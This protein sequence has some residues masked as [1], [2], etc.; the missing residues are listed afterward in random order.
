MA[1]L[2]TDME[3][4]QAESQRNATRTPSPQLTPCEQ[5]KY[6]K[7]QLAKME[8]FRRCKQACVDA[9]MMMPDHHP[10]E[11]FYVRALTELHDIEE[12]MALAVSTHFNN[13]EN[14]GPVA[15][16]N[17]NGSNNSASQNAPQNQLP[18]PIMLFVEKNYKAQMAAI[19][20]AFPKIRSRLTDNWKEAIIFPIK[21][22]GKDFRLASSYRPISLLS[23]IGKLTESI[24]LHRLKNFINE[25]NILN[26]NQY[27][28][29][30]KL[31]T[32]H[33]LLRLTENISEGFQKKKSTGAVFLD[34]QKAFDH[35]WINGLTFKLI[36]FKIP[37]PLIHLIHSYLTNRSFRIRINE[38]LSNE[39]SVSAGCPQGSL[40]GPLLFNLYIT[41]IPDYSLTKINLYADDT[42][43]HA[44]YKKLETISFALNKHLLLLQN[45]YDK[46]KISI[47]VEKS[48]AIIF[49]KKQSL[50]PPIIMYNTQIPWSQEAKYL[51]IIF[52]TH[53]TWKQHIYYVR[54]KFRKIMFK[55]Y[56]L[57]GRNSHLSIENKVLL[58]TAVMRPI[59]AYACPVWGYAAKTNINILDTLQ[60]SLIRMI[61]KAIRY[62]RNDDIRNALKIK[63]FKSHIQNIAINFFNDLEATNNINMQNLS[64]YTPNDNTKR[65]RRILLDSY[66]PP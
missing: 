66:N 47:N 22:P 10:D 54:D 44:T 26:P 50:P 53:L 13:L 18:P 5:L 8:T 31:S 52:D 42:A 37:H 11:P 14:S 19:T 45:F 63:S 23:T 16:E 2:P 55:L 64:Q 30:N 36:T 1:N 17:P 58:Y 21:K 9:L 46:W 24:I 34:I 33:P 32:L 60:N 59:L 61:V 25:N 29:T 12:A 43:I 28:F 56:P 51:G 27:G 3:L 39:H 48:T 57:I 6:N 15:N 62:M 35:V 38:T 4:E 7:A 65:P 41:D 20:K 40:L 49:T